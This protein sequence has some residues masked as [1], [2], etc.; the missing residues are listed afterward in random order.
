MTHSRSLAFSKDFKLTFHT[1]QQTSNS[2]HEVGI[3]KKEKSIYILKT[4]KVGQQKYSFFLWYGL[5][6]YWLK[7]LY[8]KAIGDRTAQ[9]L[10]GLI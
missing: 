5:L 2:N 8:K 7:V 1:I 3:S 4:I 10:S 6:W 9:E